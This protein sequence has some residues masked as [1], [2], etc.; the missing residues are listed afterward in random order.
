MERL[1]RR[2]QEM[3]ANSDGKVSADEY[4]GR[5]PFE[6]LDGN[7]DGF[8]DAADLEGLRP[9]GADG[10]PRQPF[11]SMDRNGDGKVTKDEYRGNTPFERLDRNGDGVLDGEDLRGAGSG[12]AGRGPGERPDRRKLREA[13]KAMD[14]DG[15]GK[16]S[17]DEYTGPIPFERLDRDNDGFLTEKDRQAGGRRGRELDPEAVKERFRRADANGDGKLDASE[18]P[19]PEM[20]QRLDE[21]GDGYLTPEELERARQRGRQGRGGRGGGQGSQGQGLDRFDR[22][23]D[24]R[25]SRDEFPG[26]DERFEQ[27]DRN[28]DGWITPDEQGGAPR[29]PRPGGSGP[30]GR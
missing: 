25:I 14:T 4:R 28:Q 2:F 1:R 13:M 11:E 18:F 8:L 24:G 22:D 21:N 10:P 12:D 17:K 15:D 23:G 16:I 30:G 20:F 26:S 29:S 7:G 5:I 19:R 27:L 6:R 3:D 9:G